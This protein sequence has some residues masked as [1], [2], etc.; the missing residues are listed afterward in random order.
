M[1]KVLSLSPD[2]AEE[3]D[4]LTKNGAPPTLLEEA[5]GRSAA[6]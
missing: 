1:V 3:K 2:R 4:C 5:A 6:R